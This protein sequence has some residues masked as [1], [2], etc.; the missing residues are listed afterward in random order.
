MIEEIKELS[1]S[2]GAAEVGFAAVTPPEELSL[3]H[4]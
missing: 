2:L 1:C 3:I 4:I